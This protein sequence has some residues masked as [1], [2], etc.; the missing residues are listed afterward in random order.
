[1]TPGMK[2]PKVR[3]VRAGRDKTL[4][5]KFDNGVAKLYDCKPLLRSEPFRIL[6]NDAIFRAAH[7]DA[8]GY[9]VIWNDDIDLAESEIWLNGKNEESSAESVHGSEK[10]IVKTG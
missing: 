6:Q 10:G 4:W 5:V 2:Y 1:M 7:A 9:G 8:N 3:S